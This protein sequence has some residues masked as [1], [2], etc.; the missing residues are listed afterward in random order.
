[1]RNPSIL[2]G[3]AILAVGYGCSGDGGGPEVP[4]KPTD[5]VPVAELGAP[6]GHLVCRGIIHEHS[7]YSHD[8]CDDYPRFDHHCVR[9]TGCRSDSECP[10]DHVCKDGYCAGKLTCSSESDCLP[11]YA[12]PESLRNE[13]CFRDARAGM[14]QSGQDFV[15]LTDHASIFA[16]FEYPEVLLYQEGDTLIQRGGMPV[17][18]RAL[19]PDGRTVIVAAGTETYMMPIGLE[20][21]VGATPSERHA[22]YEA[23]GGDA[24]R[25]LQAA[26]ALVFLQHTEGW[27]LSYILN[28]P[29]DGIEIYNTHFNLLANAGAVLDLLA[30]LTSNPELLPAP[31]LL[32]LP[33]WQ[34]NTA[35]L[36]RWS[37]ASESKRLTGV[38]AT[39]AHRNALPGDAGDGERMDSFRR[40]M[41][42]FSNYLLLD[43]GEVDDLQLKNAIRAGHG[44]GVFHFLGYPVGF[45]FYGQDGTTILE[46]GDEVRT[47]AMVTLRVQRP[48]VYALDPEAEPPRIVARLL[49]A[50]DGGWTEIDSAEGDLQRDVG[51]GVYRAE[52]R[53]MPY[54]L[55]QWLGREPNTYIK[56]VVWVYSNPIYVR[57]AG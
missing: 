30:K 2:I 25:A 19:C 37:R 5:V 42:W 6:R 29:I 38:L 32:L 46:M 7:P 28:Q 21:H 20:H 48:R 41:H 36:E 53:M 22:A 39:D 1:M 17:A 18:N 31:E 27:D 47:D 50:Q 13:P 26:G 15:F 11:D 10:G 9:E 3:L 35:D 12:C 34:E 45:D 55:R 43:P 54:H 56:E 52:I 40:M 16:D 14:C 33:I 44:F 8:A 49:R 24:I 57:P 4:W 51:A 23:E